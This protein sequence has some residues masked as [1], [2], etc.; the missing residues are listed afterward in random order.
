VSLDEFLGQLAMVARHG[1]FDSANMSRIAQL[2]NKTNQFNLTTRR[3]NEAQ[4]REMS[5]AP[6][7]WTQ[8]FRLQD[9]YGDSGLIGVMACRPHDDEPHAW[10]IDLWLLSCRVL[11]RRM[12]D[13]MFNEVISAA[14]RRGIGRIFGRYFPTAKNSQVADLFPRLGFTLH[15]D[16]GRGAATWSIDVTQVVPRCVQIADAT[17]P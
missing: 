1:V 7:W 8:W 9:R 14:S 4:L 10:E 6:G 15:R 13:Y 2:V 3:Y 11:G 5:V 17:G 16:D 12:E